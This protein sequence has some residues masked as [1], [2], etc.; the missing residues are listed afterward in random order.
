NIDLGPEVTST[1]EVGADLSFLDNRFGMNV[2]WY[3]ASTLDAL[4]E[5]PEPPVTGLGSQIRN[6]GEISN[7]GWEMSANAQVLSM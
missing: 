1:L 3:D 4:F 7:T 6:V 5:V 2:T